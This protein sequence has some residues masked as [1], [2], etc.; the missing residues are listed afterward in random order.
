MWSFFLLDRMNLM[1]CWQ[2]LSGGYADRCGGT[3]APLEM[4][5]EDIEA[6]RRHLTRCYRSL[7]IEF[8]L[9]SFA[10]S[11]LYVNHDYMATKREVK[12]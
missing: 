2:F 9:C 11:Q 10:R 7:E 8:R 4:G 5:D 1:I 6:V 12:H 3:G